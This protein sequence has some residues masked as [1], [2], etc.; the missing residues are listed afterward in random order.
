MLGFRSSILPVTQ[1]PHMHP[2]F[3]LCNVIQTTIYHTAW[4]C[5]RIKV[6]WGFFLASYEICYFPI[7][8]WWTLKVEYFKICLM[9]RNGL[10]SHDHYYWSCQF[11]TGFVCYTARHD[12]VRFLNLTIYYHL[13]S[14]L[15]NL[16]KL[17]RAQEF[18]LRAK[19]SDGKSD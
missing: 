2:Q 6:M 17:L 11:I 15:R 7:F 19:P 1:L 16:S 14:T 10:I 12:L 9:V 18:Q 4:G 13:K 5:P 8:Q 3:S